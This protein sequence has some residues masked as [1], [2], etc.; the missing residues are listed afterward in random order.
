MTEK[1]PD[2]GAASAMDEQ[3]P[4]RVADQILRELVMAATYTSIK[5]ILRP[6]LQFMK[7]HCQWDEPGLSHAIHTFEAI[8]YSIQSDLSYIVIDKLMAHLNLPTND[9]V[10][11]ASIAIV[12]SKI[13]GIGV[14]D[15]T[16]GP[17]VLEIINELLKHLKK[18]AE[19]EKTYDQSASAPK[20]QFQ[21]ALLE[22]LGEYARK[23][24]DF[25]KIEIMTFHSAQSPMRL[26]RR[27]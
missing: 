2:L 3:S 17:A 24:P 19:K 9:V 10:Q 23:M 22:S 26:Q 1:T 18:S 5:A 15:W 13:I 7:D 14:G 12:L 21:H 11:K 6:V 25:Q 4:S 8:M 27:S 16:V 20:Q